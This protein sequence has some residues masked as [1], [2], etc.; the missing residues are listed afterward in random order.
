[1]KVLIAALC[2]LVV[3]VAW[4]MWDDFRDEVKARRNADDKARVEAV[5]QRQREAQDAY[6]STPR[7]TAR[8][9]KVMTGYIA[10]RKR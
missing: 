8:D 9:A 3:A 7:P 10:K 4:R 2:C 6:G 5:C 1:M